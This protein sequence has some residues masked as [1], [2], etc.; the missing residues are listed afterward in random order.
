MNNRDKM[1]ASNAKAK[2]WLERQGYSQFHMFPH[3]RFSSDLNFY[4]LKFD[5]IC[6]NHKLSKICIF[7]VKSNCKPTISYQARMK[8]FANKYG[9]VCLWLNVVDYKGVEVYGA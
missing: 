5:G 4:E 2:D 3:T 6:I 9:I 8:E 1:K 7:Q